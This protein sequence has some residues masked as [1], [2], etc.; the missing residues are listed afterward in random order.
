[1]ERA[2]F[3][4]LGRDSKP[5]RGERMEKK[6]EEEFSIERLRAA[7]AVFGQEQAIQLGIIL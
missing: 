4:V 1:M 2:T 5:H 6:F 7:A 3:V